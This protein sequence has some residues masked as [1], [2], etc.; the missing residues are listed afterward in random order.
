MI[1]IYHNNRCGKSREALEFLTQKG[2]EFE[3]VEYLK[4]P[5]TEIEL[6]EL[7]QLLQIKP[8]DLVRTKEKIWQENYKNID[9]TEIELLKIIAE[10]P[11]L[12]ERP[13]VVNGKKALIARPKELIN[14]IL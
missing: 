5:L 13:I 7:I 14:N 9:F 2:I 1:I 8:I 6:Q 4:N 11:I 12:I 10:N 3:I